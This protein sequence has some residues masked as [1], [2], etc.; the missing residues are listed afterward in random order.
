MTVCA[1]YHALRYLL[2]YPL[3]PVS[4]PNENAHLP[5]FVAMNVI[6]VKNAY[7]GLATVD[8]RVHA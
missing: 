8:A 5:S 2:L 1:T 6:E 3:P 7:V 4:A